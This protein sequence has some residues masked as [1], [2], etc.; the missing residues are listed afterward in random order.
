MRLLIIALL[1]SGCHVQI[2]QNSSIKVGD[3]VREMG[4]EYLEKVTYIAPNGRVET[5]RTYSDGDFTLYTYSKEE[6][7]N[8]IPVECP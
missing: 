6:I 2:S 3:C 4:R 8:L 5:K 1:L 7:N